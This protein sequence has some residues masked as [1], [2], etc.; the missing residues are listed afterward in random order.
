LISDFN[1]L[2]LTLEIIKNFISIDMDNLKKFLT[3]EELANQNLTELRK[4]LQ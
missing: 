2:I 3:V 4:F 1:D